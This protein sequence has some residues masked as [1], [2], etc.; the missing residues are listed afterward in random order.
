[1]LIFATILAILFFISVGITIGGISY[2]EDWD[3]VFTISGIILA[4][5]L[6]IFAGIGIHS[7][8]N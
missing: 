8:F 7:L 1:M 5:T 3:V 2:D 6:L 4:I